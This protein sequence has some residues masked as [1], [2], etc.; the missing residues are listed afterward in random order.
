MK[1]LQI[2]LLWYTTA[3]GVLEWASTDLIPNDISD[4]A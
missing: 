3:S 2:Y 1:C 4:I